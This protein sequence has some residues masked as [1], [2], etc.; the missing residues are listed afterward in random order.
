MRILTGEEDFDGLTKTVATLP[1]AAYW[2]PDWHKRE[3]DKVF[4]ARW[5]YLCHSS[6]ISKP[7]FAALPSAPRVFSWY[8]TKMEPCA[9]FTI[10]VDIAAPS[11]VRKHRA[12]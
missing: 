12:Y 10:P 3:L 1:G 11:F 2:D 4:Y 8:G 6:S 5:L 9:A 7:P